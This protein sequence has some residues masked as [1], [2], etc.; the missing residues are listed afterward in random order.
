MRKACEGGLNDDYGVIFNGDKSKVKYTLSIGDDIIL[1]VDWDFV[2]ASPTTHH[3]SAQTLQ[4]SKAAKELFS[5]M[6]NAVAIW[7]NVT[8]DKS[9]FDLDPAPSSLLHNKRQLWRPSSMSSSSS[10]RRNT[11]AG[12]F[13]KK[14]TSFNSIYD[15][16]K[17][18]ICTI[19]SHKGSWD[20][21]CCNENI[22]LPIYLAMGIGNDAFWPPTVDRGST[23]EDII[24]KYG[25]V[26]QGC[27]DPSGGDLGYPISFDPWSQW[28][29]DLYGGVRISSH[30]NI[31]FS[32]GMLDPWSAGGV[33]PKGA[34]K[35]EGPSVQPLN[36]DASM[37]ALNLDLGAHHLDLMFSTKDDPDC[38]I[39]ARNTEQEYIDA[40]IRQ[41][42]SDKNKINHEFLGD[43][44]FQASL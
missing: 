25:S 12:S 23:M 35:T 18:D 43:R 21:L 1:D 13:T 10:L 41:W 22:N 34:G 6:K 3:G 40:W 31:I 33:Y 30:S 15:S 37:I 9:C 39:M 17:N 28:M 14:E 42:N 38:A 27:A 11:A 20:A 4:D 16:A 19:E 8:K 29:D 24:G 5:S 2:E 26:A 44:P 7:F 32:N 36:E